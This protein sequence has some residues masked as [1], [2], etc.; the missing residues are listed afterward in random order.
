MVSLV[1][2]A[3]GVASLITVLSVMNGFAGELRDRILSLVPH[4]QVE[5]SQPLADW[6]ALA[7]TIAERQEVGF[8][9]ESVRRRVQALSERPAASVP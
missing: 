9:P 4:V 1:G 6:G 3:L 2:M 8:E 7:A 5:S